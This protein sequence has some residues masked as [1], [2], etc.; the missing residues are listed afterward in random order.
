MILVSV[1]DI[2]SSICIEA[3]RWR[4]GG[5]LFSTG[6]LDSIRLTLFLQRG[7]LEGKQP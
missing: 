2:S 4:G 6:T 3:G 7:R 5:S 1:S